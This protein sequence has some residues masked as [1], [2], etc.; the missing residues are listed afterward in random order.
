MS[1][2]NTYTRRC[3]ADLP[4]FQPMSLEALLPKL[5][6]SGIDLVTRMLA[7]VPEQRISAEEALK[8]AFFLPSGGPAAAATPTTTT[9]GTGTGEG[10]ISSV[11]NS[12]EIPSIG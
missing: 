3:Q 6:A 4:V 2:S 8:H 11:T 10:N 1:K 7:Y 9:V 12:P 5:D